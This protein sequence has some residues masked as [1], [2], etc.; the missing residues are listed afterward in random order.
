MFSSITA[1]ILEET[2]P[3]VH[4]SPLLAHDPDTVETFPVPPDPAGKVSTSLILIV[5]LKCS[6]Y[7]Y[8]I[9]HEAI[10][11]KRDFT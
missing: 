2:H 10:A 9:L 8:D 3:S 4:G 7:K 1:Q 11:V 5:F 6:E